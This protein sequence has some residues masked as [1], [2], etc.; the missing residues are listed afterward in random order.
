MV[1]FYLI[2]FLIGATLMGLQFLLGLLGLGH[3]H[4]FGGHEVG[5]HDVGG[6]DVGGHDVHAGHGEHEHDHEGEGSWFASLLTFRTLT[7]AL[8]FFGLAGLAGYRQWGPD[9]WP[10]TLAVAVAG[11]GGALLL[12]ARLMLWL[13]RQ[14]ASGTVHIDRAVGQPATVY[15]TVPAQKAGAGK[16]QVCVQN[17][18]ME[19]QAV[20][21]DREL[22]TGAKV[23]VVSVVNADT[24][25]VVP[26][27]EPG[28]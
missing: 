20:T 19:Y 7:A 15:L 16:V 12:V 17:R 2:C 27:T 24:V 8:T 9:G 1:T 26:A 28:V 10:I 14:T 6:H 23:V 25:E 3:L 11:G 22:P 5:G 4:D 13:R 18:T 21:P